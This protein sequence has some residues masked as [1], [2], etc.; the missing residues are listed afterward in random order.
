MSDPARIFVSGT[1]T[2]VGKTVVTRGIV[3]ALVRRG[4]D[5][6]AAKPVES[7]A[8]RIDGRLVPA[9]ARAL[10]AA[11]GRDEEIADVCAYCF[12]DPVSPHLAAARVG[13]R[14]REAPV[15][16]LLE[17]RSRGA[18]VVVA[19][20]A[21]GLLVPLSD[22][23]LYV[24]LIARTGFS[25]VVVSPNVLGAIN[26]TLLTIEAARRRGIEVAGVVLNR[27]PPT[28]LGNAAAIARHGRVR[29]LGELP[30]A[31]IEDGAGL[32]E[33]AEARIDLDRLV[34]RSG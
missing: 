30:D 7:G 32:A 12:P 3:G 24:D 9:D 2:E 21:G 15:L 29:I 5:V 26:A 28:E 27:T 1:D 18:D 16:D 22:E 11:S 4:L 13:E 34:S 20:G 33:L 14:I 6:A 19:E 10:L 31:D 23:L 25:L 17:R 8:E